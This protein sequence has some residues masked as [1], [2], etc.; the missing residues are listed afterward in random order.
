MKSPTSHHIF[1]ART[2]LDFPFDT[3]RTYLYL[4]RGSAVPPWTTSLSGSTWTTRR[5]RCCRR[6]A[7]RR[8]LLMQQ[9]ASRLHLHLRP[10]LLL[11]QPKKQRHPVRRIRGKRWPTRSRP[12]PA[13]RCPRRRHRRHS[14]RTRRPA[15]SS[16]AC[17]ASAAPPSASACSGKSRVRFELFLC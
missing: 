15:T 2:S 1:P 6:P 5:P 11:H 17:R 16:C 9:P 7:L 12:P 10:P 3:L 4:G 13:S 8:L 14:R